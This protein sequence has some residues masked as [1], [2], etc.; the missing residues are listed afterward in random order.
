[1]MMYLY[2]S[3]TLQILN[4]TPHCHE[5]MCMTRSW[6]YPRRS[7][8]IP[9]QCEGI[10]RLRFPR[11]YWKVSP[12][13]T[14]CH[15]SRGTSGQLLKLFTAS[16]TSAGSKGVPTHVDFISGSKSTRHRAKGIGYILGFNGVFNKSSNP[17]IILYPH[18]SKMVGAKV[19][20][21]VM[22]K[23]KI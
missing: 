20:L 2:R 3:I 7:G 1:M 5:H 17:Y 8:M 21:L 9:L 11:K 16:G 6:T 13:S 4:R 22:L 15:S 14:N 12:K 19:E 18:I 10:L 23:L